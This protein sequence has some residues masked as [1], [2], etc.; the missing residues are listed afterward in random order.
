MKFKTEGSERPE[1]KAQT[2]KRHGKLFPRAFSLSA[3][4]LSI[5][6]AAI[7]FCHECHKYLVQCHVYASGVSTAIA[8]PADRQLKAAIQ[9][10][11][12]YLSY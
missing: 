9:D 2:Y 3:K 11:V 5:R 4:D 6:F 7:K 1:I 8:L 10:S 12:G